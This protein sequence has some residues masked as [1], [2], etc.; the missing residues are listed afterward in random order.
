MVAE[1][2]ASEHKILEI[3]EQNLLDVLKKTKPSTS[4]LQVEEYNT[5]KIDFERSRGLEE[6]HIESAK[7]KVGFND[8]IGLEEAKK[9]II[10]AIQIPLLHP[11]L[12]KEYD[13]KNVNG[14]L[15]F[16]PPGN[17]KTMLMRAISTEF[18]NVT[19]LELDAPTL[20]NQGVDMA[21]SVIKTI[22][23]RAQENTPAIIFIDE[24]EALFPR[25]E[26]ASIAEAQVTTEALRQM[27]GIRKLTGVVVVAATNK[28]DK[29]D[30]ALLRAGR[31]DKL[32]FVKPPDR[33]GRALLFKINL[34]NVPLADDV[35]FDK[36]ADESR[37]FTG[38]DI[39]GIAR[40][41]KMRALDESI[42]TSEETKITM[43]DLETVVEDTKPSAPDSEMSTYLNFL[44]AYGER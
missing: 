5:F 38:A 13:I 15:L 21:T 17:G 16:G 37:G 29:L 40:E 12:V 27:D 9:A 1:E 25:R 35:D 24:I 11:D 28:P 22:F 33:N 30:S 42:K 26:I 3:T 7:E 4:L 6:S 19:L 20:H 18:G 14:I 41:V 39:A 32:I 44:A 8:V 23:N 43:N 10:D 2:A 36:L 34:G 31:F